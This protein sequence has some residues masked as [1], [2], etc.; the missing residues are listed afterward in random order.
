MKQLFLVAVLSLTLFA[1]DRPNKP[2]DHKD[3]PVPPVQSSRI[4][5]NRGV[6]SEN[7]ADRALSQ[8]I[9]QAILAD[10]GISPNAKNIV[11]VTVNGVVTLQGAVSSAAEKEAIAKKVRNITGVVEM[12]NQ[13]EVKRS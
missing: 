4:D 12:D 2:N 9:R 1:C 8:K 7:P 5:A 6:V 3:I 13:L 11:V 10:E